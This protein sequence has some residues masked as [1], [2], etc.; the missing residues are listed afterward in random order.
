MIDA[1]LVGPEGESE[2]DL[3]LLEDMPNWAVPEFPRNQVDKAGFALIANEID[4]DE[5]AWAYGVINNWRSAHSYP[6]LN[7]RVNLRRKLK[8]VCPTGVLR[9]APKSC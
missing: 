2:A 5:L 4:L 1:F 8:T 7:F 9:A 6:L 3:A